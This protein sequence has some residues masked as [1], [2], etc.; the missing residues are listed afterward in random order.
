[1]H[2]IHF[3][4]TLLAAGRAPPRLHELDEAQR[5]RAYTRYM[6]E[7]HPQSFA[8]DTVEIAG[9]GHDADAMF[10]SPAGLAELFGKT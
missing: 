3:I 2:V 7:R 5:G 6:R 1:M 10:G 8:H 4:D 9:A